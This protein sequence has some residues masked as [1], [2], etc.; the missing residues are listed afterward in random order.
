MERG[1]SRRKDEKISIWESMRRVSARV[2]NTSRFSTI[3]NA[4]R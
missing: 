4:K 3:Y 2:E 1:L